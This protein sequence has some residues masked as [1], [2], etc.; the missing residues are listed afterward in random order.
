MT[1][2]QKYNNAEKYVLSQYKKLD[3][4]AEH[5][6][7]D[8]PRTPE[9]MHLKMLTLIL[10]LTNK[11][12]IVLELLKKCK[13]IENGK[14]SYVKYNQGVCESIWLYYLYFG[15]IQSNSIDLL[16]EIYDESKQVFDN[17]KK[18]EYSLLIS[19]FA[20]CL[21]AS[22]VKAITCDPFKKETG[23]KCIDGQKL[24]KPLFPDLHDSELL[25]AQRDSIILKSSTY[26]YQLESNIK[27]I[28]NKC[29]GENISGHDVFCVGAIFINASTSFEEFYSYLFHEKYGVYSKLLKSNVDAIVLVSLDAKND[30]MLNNIYESGYV[31]T[32]L[33]NPTARNKRLCKLFRLDNYIA[34][35]KS[36]NEE[37]YKKGQEE[38]GYYKI[39]CRDGYVNIIPQ[40]ASE[41]E[42]EAYIKYLSSSDIR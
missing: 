5:P 11:R 29:R 9:S 18:F 36:I 19:G 34:L 40:D 24:I 3:F 38:Y 7:N 25:C 16:K 32:V 15:L 42:I 4:P 6:F 27:K 8:Y 22:E 2:E 23:L 12:D 33:V 37:M 41:P 28:I 31:Q 10:A 20:N 30:L 26:Y 35:G 39:L 14:F 13:G 17:G 21:M 1:T